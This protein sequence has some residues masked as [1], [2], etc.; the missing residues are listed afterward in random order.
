MRGIL[1][2]LKQGLL[3]K[4]LLLFLVSLLGFFGTA[5]AGYSPVYAA[6]LEETQLIPPEYKPTPEEKIERAYEYSEATGLM[7]EAKQARTNSNRNFDP[8]LKANI[9]NIDAQ[10]QEGKTSLKDKAKGLL[11]KIAK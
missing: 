1:S 9:K 2:N 3:Q 7:E 11:E 5:I 4:L 8:N 10:A 6:T